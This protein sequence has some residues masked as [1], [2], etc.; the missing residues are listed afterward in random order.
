MY[1]DITVTDGF[2]LELILGE[3]TTVVLADYLT[4]AQLL[5]VDSITVKFAERLNDKDIPVQIN[6]SEV[7]LQGIYPGIVRVEIVTYDSLGLQIVPLQFETR[8]EIRTTVLAEIYTNAGCVNCPEANHS[9]DLLYEAFPENFTAIRYHVFWTDPF[10]P[11]NLYNPTEVED[12]RVFSGN[13]Y[14][15]PKIYMNGEVVNYADYSGLVSSVSQNI[16]AGADVHIWKPTYMES[17]DSLF[18]DYKVE[19][20]STPLSDVLI[21]SVLTQDSIYYEGTNGE[22]IHMQ[23]MRDITSSVISELSSE[24]IMSHSLK[25]VP[26]TEDT[27][28]LNL[29]LFVQDMSSRDILQVTDYSVS[30]LLP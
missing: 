20:F 29:V 11:M 13:S 9:I 25:R 19:N 30:E 6:T 28:K 24:V 26:H 1:L 18:I 21:Y 8:T 27:D 3:W 2:P 17:A 10:D 5:Q 23:V 16:S 12:R 14:E 15:A 22:K 7:G 4:E